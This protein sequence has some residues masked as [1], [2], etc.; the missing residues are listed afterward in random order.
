M[1]TYTLSHLEEI[2]GFIGDI[3]YAEDHILFSIISEIVT[4]INVPTSSLK[5]QSDQD[6]KIGLSISIFKMNNLHYLILSSQGRER[7]S[8]GRKINRGIPPSDFSLEETK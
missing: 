3:E 4:K 5:L 6:L 2:K 8:Q 7:C 1:T